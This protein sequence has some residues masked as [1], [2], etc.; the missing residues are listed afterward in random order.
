MIARYQPPKITWNPVIESDMSVPGAGGRT[1]A[2]WSAGLNKVARTESGLKGRIIRAGSSNAGMTPA[3]MMNVMVFKGSNLVGQVVTDVNGEFQIKDLV[4]GSYNLIASGADGFAV[5]GFELVDTNVALTSNA[6]NGHTYVAKALI[7]APALVIQ[8]APADPS[9]LQDFPSS[10][11]SSM[12]QGFPI[13]PFAGDPFGF[14]S[15]AGGFGGGGGGFGGGAGGGAGGGFG[16][17]GGL[18]AAGAIAAA[19][20]SDNNNS[21]FIPSPASPATP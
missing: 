15:G 4:G 13:D 2:D 18:L 16:G 3:G 21:N 14:G 12:D 17:L 6:V 7:Q 8:V 11:D 9:L 1:D 20:L 19:G 10:D 5:I